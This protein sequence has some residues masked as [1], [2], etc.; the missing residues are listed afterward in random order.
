MSYRPHGH[1][2]VNAGSPS[3]WGTC[4]RCGFNY[5][6]RNLNWQFDWRGNGYV[7]LRL[8]V[9]D[10]CMDLPS[11]WYNTIILPPDPPP[12]INARPEPYTID[13]VNWLTT[14]AAALTERIILTTED[15]G[16]QLTDEGSAYQPS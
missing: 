7:N 15:G 6:L 13:E 16:D 14:E 9:C 3:C 12:V 4:D 10:K 5:N 2:S 1:A 8:L 11:P